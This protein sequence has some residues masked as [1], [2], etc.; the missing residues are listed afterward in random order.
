MICFFNQR[1]GI[2]SGAAH[3][4]A[5]FDARDYLPGDFD[6]NGTID[7]VDFAILADHFN[8][9]G[10]YA[11]GDISFNGHVNLADFSKFHRAYAAAQGGAAAAAV[12]EP[13]SQFLI[14]HRM[15]RAGD[16]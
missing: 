10:L 3:I 1:N 9:D 6:S 5:H 13:S 12:P 2:H 11:E 4:K 14:G 15:S 16:R 8:Q 7:L